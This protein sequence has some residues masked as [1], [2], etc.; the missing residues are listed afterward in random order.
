MG[1]MGC[2]TVNMV[3]R[4]LR[5]HELWVPGGST[6]RPGRVPIGVEAEASEVDV[7]GYPRWMRIDFS[8]P[9]RGKLPPVKLT[10][11]TGGRKPP[12]ELLRGR[13]MT[14]W[15]ALLCGAKGAIFS[16]CPWN[17]RFELLPKK[18][19]EGFQ[20]PVRTLPRTG[21]H[22]AEWIEAC[23]GRGQTFCSFAIGGPLTELI[24]LGNAA[25]LVGEKFKYDV[26]SGRILGV[27]NADRYLHREYRSGWVL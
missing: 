21:G 24:Q 12:Q 3:F 15:G 2:H 16:D 25:V 4:A 27:P 20:G 9:A 19:F 14:D 18:E 17:T 22:H 8:L 23:K 13:E 10:F 26:L 11:Y 6:P 7:E 1:D 5:L